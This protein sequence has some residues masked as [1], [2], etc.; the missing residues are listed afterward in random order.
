LTGKETSYHQRERW[1]EL[2]EVLLTELRI[3]ATH[4]TIS[5]VPSFLA[6]HLR[7]RLWKKDKRQMSEEGK[8]STEEKAQ[9]LSSEE[10]KNCPDCGGTNFFYPKGFEGGVTRCRHEKLKQEEPPSPVPQKS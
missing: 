6:E 7:R 2:A 9:P 3:A 1:Q 8:S 4:T 5:S 10:S